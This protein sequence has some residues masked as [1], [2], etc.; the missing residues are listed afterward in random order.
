MRATRKFWFAAAELEEPCVWFLAESEFS[1]SYGWTAV[2][3]RAIC[4][5]NARNSKSVCPDV[6]VA[7]IDRGRPKLRIYCT[8]SIARKDSH[9]AVERMAGIAGIH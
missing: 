8:S 5:T 1:F 2:G 6:N 9:G 4:V 3:E 7:S